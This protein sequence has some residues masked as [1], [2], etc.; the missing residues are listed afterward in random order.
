MASGLASVAFDYGAAREHL[1]DG[2]HG[3]APA[4]EDEAAFI[5]AALRLAS[6]DGARRRMGAAARQAVSDLHPLDVSRRFADLLSS[7]TIK[8][9]AA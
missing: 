5:A 4:R 8:E 6:D 2:E 3:H 9:H 7:L 1:R